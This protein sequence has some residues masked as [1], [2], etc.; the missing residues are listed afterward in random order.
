VLSLSKHVA[1]SFV[2]LY[3]FVRKCAALPFDGLRANG[4]FD[5]LF[6]HVPVFF[7]EPISNN[8]RVDVD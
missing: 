7:I 5:E 2:M 6:K 8:G 1:A 3:G 4:S